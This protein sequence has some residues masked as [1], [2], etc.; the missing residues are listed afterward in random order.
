MAEEVQPHL[1]SGKERV[2]RMNDLLADIDG[3]GAETVEEKDVLTRRVK[4]VENWHR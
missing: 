4:Q 1:K 3:E 2:T